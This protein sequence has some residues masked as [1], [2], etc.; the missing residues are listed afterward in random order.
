MCLM[1]AS[2]IFISQSVFSQIPDINTW[3]EFRGNNCSGVARPEQNPPVDLVSGENLVWKTPIISGVSSPC[4]W[5]DRIFLTGFDNENKQLQVMCYERSNGKLIWNR[6]VPAKEIELYHVTASPA[7][8]TTA[9]DG[10]RIYVHFGSYGLL[11]YDFAGEVLWTFE[12][13]V[14]DN[15]FG[16]GTSPI[17]ADNLVILKVRRPNKELYLLAL[18]SKSGQQVWKLSVSGAGASTPI[19]WGDDLVVHSSGFIAG[20]HVKDGTEIW[21]VSVNTNG[22]STPVVNDDIL[23]V[24]TWQHFGIENQRLTMPSYQD[25]LKNYD[26]DG[27]SLISKKEFPDDFIIMRRPEIQDLPNASIKLEEYWGRV[28]TDKNNYFDSSEWQKYLDLYAQLSIDHGLL[29]IKFGGTGDITASHILWKENEGV[30]EVPSPLLYKGRIYMIKNGGIVTCLNALTGE[31]IYRERLGASGPYF[32]SPVA[33]NDRIYIASN[34][35]I[36]VVFASGDELNVLARNILR[37][38]ILATPA[39]VDNKLYI[40]TDKHLYAFG[41]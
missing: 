21:R 7:D 16:T 26:T 40:R 36:V 30:P 10:E 8:A 5:G 12:L 37:E 38:K 14:N 6:I 32:S 18:D 31:F 4:I 1:V 22:I 39:I 23:F 24:G 3:P 15:R 19:M 17:V 13:P 2:S 29:A 25:L 27:D 41:D 35:G 33:A 9:T 11:C 34:K 20:Y 28:D